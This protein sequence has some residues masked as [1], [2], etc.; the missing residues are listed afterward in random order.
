MANTDSI[1]MLLE[2]AKLLKNQENFEAALEILDSLYKKHPNSKEVK[3]NLTETLFT[4]GGFLN[5]DYTLEYEKARLIFERIINLNPKDY[6]AHYNLGIAYFNLGKSK[7][8]E[9][10]FNKAL[11]IKPDYKYCLYNL[12]LIYETL[13]NYKKALKYYEKALKLDPNFTY[14]LSAQKQVKIKLDELN[15]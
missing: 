15:K 13:K 11:R 8:A 10:C 14:A 2:K 5:D 6:R 1:E 9:K 12:G 4:Y 3:K 7:N